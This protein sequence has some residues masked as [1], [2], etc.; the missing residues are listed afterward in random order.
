MRHVTR[1]NCVDL[2]WSFERINKEELV[3]I[4]GNRIHVDQGTVD[5]VAVYDIHAFL[6][7]VHQV[8]VTLSIHL[9]HAVW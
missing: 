5:I 8:E 3:A 2:E 9:L 4:K 7:C 1:T 6:P